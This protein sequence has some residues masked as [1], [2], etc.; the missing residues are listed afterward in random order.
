MLN[1]S[2]GSTVN[3]DS[4]TNTTFTFLDLAGSSPAV[5]SFAGH[6]FGSTI[7]AGGDNFALKNNIVADGDAHANDVGLVLQLSS[8][9]FVSSTWAGDSNGA[10]VTD[11]V[12]TDGQTATFGTNA[13]AT[14]QDAINAYHAG[15]T[16]AILVNAGAYGDTNVNQNA[17]IVLQPT[18][19]SSTIS[20]ASLADASNV[21]AS[22][23]IPTGTTL[24]VGGDNAPTTFAGVLGGSGTFIKS[25]TGTMTLDQTNVF[26]GTTEIAAGTLQLGNAVILGTLGTVQSPSIPRE[27][28]SSMNRAR[29]RLG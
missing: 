8:N 9:Y 14:I 7:T 26:L 11:A 5:G 17:N 16:T 13:F 27:F 1:L 6:A 21:A 23:T 3:N 4:P 28:S 12:L 15:T 18:G 19:T 29:L 25:G 10:N 2:I 22:I 20:V 24:N